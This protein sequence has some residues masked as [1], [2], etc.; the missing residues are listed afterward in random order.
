MPNS[1]QIIST[2]NCRTL[3]KYECLPIAHVCLCLTLYLSTKLTYVS[4]FNFL[5]TYSLC[6]DAMHLGPIHFPCLRIHGTFFILP[7]NTTESPC[8]GLVMECLLLLTVLNVYSENSV[9]I[10]QARLFVSG[11]TLSVKSCC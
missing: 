1:Y 7:S 3:F 6:F 8:R 11:N 2:D 4:F 5:F 9:E 10:N